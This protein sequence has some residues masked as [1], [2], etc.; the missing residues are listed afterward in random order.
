MSGDK[1]LVSDEE[2]AAAAINFV[3]A[4][5]KRRVQRV[6]RNKMLEENHC[7]RDDGRD[8]KNCFDAMRIGQVLDK[9]DICENC[10]EINKETGL[11]RRE[12]AQRNGKLR[13][14]RTL[15]K[16]RFETVETKA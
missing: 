14:L 2:L 1:L 7:F 3:L 12:T 16:R 5:L 8:V 6:K 11:L 9:L 4:D 10:V 15:V 13:R